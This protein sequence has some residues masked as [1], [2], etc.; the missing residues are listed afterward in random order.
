L[1]PLVLKPVVLEVDL[2]DIEDAVKGFDDDFEVELPAFEEEE[3][4]DEVFVEYF[5]LEVPALEDDADVPDEVFDEVVDDFRSVE[6]VVE[7]VKLDL[8][9]D[10]AEEW[11]DELVDF[12]V[13]ATVVLCR[14]VSQLPLERC[15]IYHIPWN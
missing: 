3:S 6:I 14:R 9:G 15:Y 2:V 10:I 5:E 11:L 13:D 1:A 8:P 7:L 12:V 4:I